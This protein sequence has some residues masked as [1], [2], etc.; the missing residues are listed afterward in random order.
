MANKFFKASLSVILALVIGAASFINVFAASTKQSY[1][2]DIIVCAA[3]S[4]E[5]AEAE[6]K[7]QGYKLLSDKNINESL[8]NGMYIGYKTTTNPDEAITD[9][10]A[11]NMNG[12]YSFSDYEVLLKQ[13][14]ENVASTVEGLIPMITAYRENYKAGKPI[15]V[16]V[17]T[18]LNKFYEDDSNQ[19]MGDFLL[20]CD[21]ENTEEV[22]KVF[23]QGYSAYILNIQQLL[24]IAGEDESDK[25]WI[26]EMAAADPDAVID[27]YLDTYPTPNKAYSA[28]AAEY[29]QTVNDMRVTWDA[30]NDSL[31]SIKEE[32]FV[33]KGDSV[34]VNEKVVENAVD[35]AINTPEQT[36]DKNSTEAEVEAVVT[37]SLESAKTFDDI[38]DVNLVALLSDVEYND[39]TMLDFF[40]RPEEDVSD[41]ELYTL[42][43]YMGKKL[44]DQ[45]SNVGMQQA[46]TR[47]LIDGGS[48]NSKHF[49]EI[50]ELFKDIEQI[51]IYEGVDRSL[52]E[53][54][55]ALTGPTIQK[56]NSSGKNWSDDMFSRVFQPTE[57]YKWN[58]Y[59]A[60]YI[61]PTV[62]SFIM[63]SAMYSI[64]LVM[65]S[66]MRKAS[67]EIV[68]AATQ[69][70][71]KEGT[72]LI[73]N[74]ASQAI[75]TTIFKKNPIGYLAYGK[76]LGCARSSLAYRL[77]AGV[78]CAFFIF[79]A[80]MVVVDIVMLFV[81]IFGADEAG[82]AKYSPI[83]SHI[84]DTVSTKYGDDYIA[85]NPV[86]NTL[87]N[88]GDL[89]NYLGKKG[90]FMLYYTKDKSVGNP[91]TTD[92]K[93]VTG[94][95]N[96]P[97]DYE[98]VALFGQS[99]AVNITS[100]EYTG[101]T[102]SAKGTYLYFSR[103]TTT[104]SASVFSNGNLAISLG[105]GAVIGILIGTISSKAAV[106][107]KK[108][109]A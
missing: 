27:K 68:K 88:S 90:W 36:F 73:Y 2:S 85:Y 40:M 22:T 100:D 63:Y 44:T 49:E 70:V 71:V 107:R 62:T 20:K 59:F 38:I 9:I 108:A 74:N 79:T 95:S 7:A 11:M 51:S 39:G 43:Y 109:T 50:N 13:M 5:K 53:D 30:L 81:T 101:K 48:T 54:G 94:S 65:N 91:L 96:A 16:E 46:L 6:L 55:V 34:E 42:A 75:A 45:I 72:Q 58:D 87:G 24:F 31:S 104:T 105:I 103:G 35:E 61:L 15:A 106:K 67:T 60:F 93:I 47:G 98:N 89:N 41:D 14:R 26:Q 3:D 66:V 4:A 32:Y 28:L 99:Q 86:K 17:H 1:I 52:F 57:E 77:V 19:K 78:R 69:N 82:T 97:L 102:D 10:A 21:L 12:N 76:G 83:P 64:N 56:Y 37:D 8:S 25:T 29:D 23:L 92:I 18:I 33:E 80:V 84:V